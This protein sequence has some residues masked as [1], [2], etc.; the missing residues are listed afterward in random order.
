[1]AD[2]SIQIFAEKAW[3]TY[4]NEVL[5]KKGLIT[6]ADR[7]AIKNVICRKAAASASASK[8]K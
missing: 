4:F 8:K 3:L 1:M 5:F 2:N 6:E 7:N